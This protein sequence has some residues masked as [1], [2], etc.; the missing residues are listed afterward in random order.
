MGLDPRYL[1]RLRWMRKARAVREANGSVR[2]HLGFVLADPEPHNFTY[3]LANPAELETWVSAVSGH[4]AA[5]V[6]RMLAEPAED[7]VLQTRLRGATRGHWWWSKR[8]P[9]FGRRLGWY[10]LVRLLAPSLLVETGVHDGLGSLLLLRALDRNA[11]ANGA[12]PGARLVSFD[13]NPAAGWLV[14]SDPRWDLRIKSS[15]EGLPE[16]LAEGAPVGFFL[17]DSLHTYEHELWELRTV[18]AQLATGGVLLSDNAHVTR[19]L[20]ECA[21]ELG[22][23]YHEFTE[24]PRDHFY[25]GGAVGA[26]RRPPM[27]SA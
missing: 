15:R 1:R 14:G 16:L 11:E 27:A 2:S 21:E 23:N 22:L 20:A 4:E 3:P 6:R 7:D 26:A 18:A 13:V 8:E 17:H 5:A 25:P 24:R 19:A 9:P 10:A 12:G